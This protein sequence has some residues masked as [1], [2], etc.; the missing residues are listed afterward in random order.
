MNKLF[1]VLALFVL[2]FSAVLAEN[3]VEANEGSELLGLFSKCKKST[4]NVAEV[5]GMTLSF[6]VCGK[7]RP[8]KTRYTASCSVKSMPAG[9]EKCVGLSASTGKYK[10]GKKAA[11]QCAAKYL[12]P[13]VQQC[14]GF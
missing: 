1:V 5:P 7:W 13:K 8:F 14:M 6:K 10:N 3:P 4:H 11:E 9:F 2:A 12:T